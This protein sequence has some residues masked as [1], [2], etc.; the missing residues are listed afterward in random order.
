MG[1]KIILRTGDWRGWG[2]NREDKPV[3]LTWITELWWMA[4]RGE[5]VKGEEV[6]GKWLACSDNCYIDISEVALC[7]PSWSQWC[8]VGRWR[9]GQCNISP[10]SPHQSH[11]CQG[12][13]PSDCGVVTFYLLVS[14]HTTA[15]ITSK[16]SAVAILVR[17]LRIVFPSD[18]SASSF[19]SILV[20]SSCYPRVRIRN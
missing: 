3:R 9:T 10:A 20:L 14:G 19:S 17:L 4:R 8:W 16:Y 18:L 11:V 13:L 1:K 12:F 6:E 2:E 15:N 7:R 5:R